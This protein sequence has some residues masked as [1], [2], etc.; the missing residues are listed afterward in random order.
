M[1]SMLCLL[2]SGYLRPGYFFD[3]KQKRT[4]ASMLEE[5]VRSSMHLSPLWVLECSDLFS[6]KKSEPQTTMKTR[7]QDPPEKHP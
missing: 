1:Y 5:D 2:T 7:P 4:G 6:R 3:K